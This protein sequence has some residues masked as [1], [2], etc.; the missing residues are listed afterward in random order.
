MKPIS[1]APPP[2]RPN[3]FGIRRGAAPPPPIKLEVIKNLYFQSDVELLDEEGKM[4][5]GMALPG[6]S[7]ADRSVSAKSARPPRIRL[8]SAD[9]GRRPLSLDA[10]H[11]AGI[12]ATKF[13]LQRFDVDANRHAVEVQRSAGSLS[14]DFDWAMRLG[15]H[16]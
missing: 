3:M 12:S 16:V 6:P 4:F 8:G 2:P 15:T 7:E 1:A 10:D 9:E 11:H 13:D 14:A 5:Q